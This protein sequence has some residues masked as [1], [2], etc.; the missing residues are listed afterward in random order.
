MLQSM[1]LQRVRHYQA[2]EFWQRWHQ[3]RKR[4]AL[5]SSFVL[6]RGVVS[7]F[8]RFFQSTVELVVHSTHFSS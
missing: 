2:T 5:L 7:Q 6:L 3:G 4:E 8:K 1:G